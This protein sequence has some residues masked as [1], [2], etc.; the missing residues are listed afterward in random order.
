MEDNLRSIGRGDIKL[1]LTMEYGLG[2]KNKCQNTTTTKPGND[3]LKRYSKGLKGK[4][5][6]TS[7]GQAQVA[8]V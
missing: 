3:R 4:A 7:R 1:D 2:R 8:Q 5:T 6:R